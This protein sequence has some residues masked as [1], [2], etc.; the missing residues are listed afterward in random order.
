M[1]FVIA[2]VG[3]VHGNN[4]DIASYV[5]ISSDG[6][7]GD[8]DGGVPPSDNPRAASKKAVTAATAQEPSAIG[9]PDK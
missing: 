9:M 2:H 4:Q 7:I 3:Y 5:C 8:P 6:E 1:D